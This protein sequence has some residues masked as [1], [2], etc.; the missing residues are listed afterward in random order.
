[1]DLDYIKQQIEDAFGRERKHRE[2][3]RKAKRAEY[4]RKYWAE[5]KDEI[6]EHRKFTR[7]KRSAWQREWYEK[8]R[9]KWN[10]YMRERY[11]SKKVNKGEDE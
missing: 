5:H 7:A 4:N 9:D 6:R 8:N 1:M 3:E 11:Q 10:A 2:E